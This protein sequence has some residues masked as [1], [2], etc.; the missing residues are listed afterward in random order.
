MTH[1][2]FKKST[3]IYS[4]AVISQLPA[5]VLA[6]MALQSARIMLLVF[7]LSQNHISFSKVLVNMGK[8]PLESAF[9][10]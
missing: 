2:R 7:S 1:S 4:L 6:N 5:L 10:V 3:M 9:L 8:L